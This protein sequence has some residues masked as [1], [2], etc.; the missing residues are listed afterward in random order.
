MTEIEFFLYRSKKTLIY[1]IIKILFLIAIAYL[2]VAISNYY[3]YLLI[4][5]IP[6]L[7]LIGIFSIKIYKNI[8]DYLILYDLCKYASSIDVSIIE[9]K[10]L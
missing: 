2:I 9:E 1:N 3:C 6:I 8:K 7:I 5:V 10:E 4:A